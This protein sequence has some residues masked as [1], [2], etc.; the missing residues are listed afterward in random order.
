MLVAPP[1]PSRPDRDLG[2]LERLGH[3]RFDTVNEIFEPHARALTPAVLS[4][5]RWSCLR[6]APPVLHTRG[7]TAGTLGRRGLVAGSK[8]PGKLE[9]RGVVGCGLAGPYG[10]AE[11]VG[12]VDKVEAP[13]RLV[14][15][16]PPEDVAPPAREGRGGRKRERESEG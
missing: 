11:G 9:Q 15:H 1:M 12:L 6:A 4:D 14:V 16:L 5:S 2:R 7:S 10:A 3:A 13:Q 8:R